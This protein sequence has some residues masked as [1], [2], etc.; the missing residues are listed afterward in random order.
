MS[1]YELVRIKRDWVPGW[2][3]RAFC[4]GNLA[5]FTP[6]MQILTRRGAGR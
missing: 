1:D 2:L 5:T 3:W 4:V 6:W